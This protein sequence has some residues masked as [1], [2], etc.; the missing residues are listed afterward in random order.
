MRPRVGASAGARPGHR[1]I[2]DGTGGI[3]ARVPHRHPCRHT[4][5][6]ILGVGI[7]PSSSSKRCRA[8][9]I[10][11][12]RGMSSSSSTFSRCAC[13]VRRPISSRAPYLFRADTCRRSAARW[14]SNRTRR[15]TARVARIAASKGSIHPRPHRRMGRS[16]RVRRAT[17]M[18]RAA[19]PRRRKASG[20]RR[21]DMQKANRVAAS[22]KG[23]SCLG[24]PT[25]YSFRGRPQLG[26]RQSSCPVV[27]PHQK[28]LL[29]GGC[30]PVCVS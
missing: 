16:V 1:A 19:L 7:R 6:S 26:Q 28:M 10:D 4:N 12:S 3:V 25:V 29:R 23:D 22:A 9:T 15:L 2:P 21:K 27:L 30:R 24:P 11:T 14:F 8:N 5:A 13:K 20:G 17:T 18:E